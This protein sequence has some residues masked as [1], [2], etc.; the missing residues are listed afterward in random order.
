MNITVIGAGNMGAS[1]VKQLSKAGHTVKVT[2][3]DLAKA[4]AVAAQYDNV[5][6]VAGDNAASGA[7][8]V[9][10]ATAY[11]D[12]VS[13]LQAAGNL[14]GKVV[15]DI[16]NPVADDFMSL[17]LGHVTSAA[18]EISRALPEARVVKAF[19]TVFAQVL[20]GGADFGN[21]V[22]VPVFVAS[23][24]DA[25]KAT[26]TELVQSLGFKATDAGGLVNAR[27]LEPLGGL[28]IYFGYG[29]GLGTD[30]APAWLHKSAS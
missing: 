5:T 22:T 26:V 30:I 14:S 20:G 15:I 21:G 13:A 28:N 29:A 2:A 8:I 25:A 16:S 23:D 3:R 27:Y 7:D 18:E 12:A 9:I 17:T 1:F 4:E 11:K 6:A 10:A 24:D 19:N